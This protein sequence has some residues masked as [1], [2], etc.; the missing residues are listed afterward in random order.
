VAEASRLTVLGS[1]GAWPEAGRAA[2]GF[3]LEHDG[4]RLVLDLGYATLPRLLAHCPDGDVD[5]IVVTHEHP[6]HCVDLHGLY[7]VRYF[8]PERRPRLP[9]YCTT[10]V[11][12]RLGPLE[13]DGDLTDA[14]EVHDL[15]G[16]YE[17]GPFRLESALLPHYVP[18]AGVR[19]TSAALTVAYTGDTGPDPA[20]AVLGAETD[21]YI[22][23]A[24]GQSDGVAVLRDASETR[25]HLRAD[26]AGEWARR[27]GARRLML[28]H[29][30][31]GLDRDR[32]RSEAEATF[33]GPVL[34]ADEE[35]VVPLG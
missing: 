33:G 1:C 34:I 7:R 30:W 14:F 17:I 18:N 3:L 23:D 6:D 24:T 10:G 11:M 25:F 31:P 2:S 21:L 9:L 4:F 13:P 22:V 8:A 15:P 12:T 5:A 20:L 19:L 35:L 16:T 28:T 27:A 29:F 26:E 32:S